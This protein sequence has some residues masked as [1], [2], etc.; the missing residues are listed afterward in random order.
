V[1]T[2]LELSNE[3]FA[4]IKQNM[5]FSLFYNI[6]GIPIAAR[7]L[8]GFGLVLKPELAGLAMAVSSISVVSNSL[9][10]RSFRPRQRNW[11]STIAPVVMVVVFT[12][13]F[14]EFARLSAGM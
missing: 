7:A 8:A 4:K 11:L 5:F 9:L 12:A 1:V 14:V 13:M 3:T 2:A 10:I 6:I